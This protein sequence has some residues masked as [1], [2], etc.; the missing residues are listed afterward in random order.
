VKY[1]NELV[2]AKRTGSECV[3]S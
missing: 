3:V 1:Q 2:S